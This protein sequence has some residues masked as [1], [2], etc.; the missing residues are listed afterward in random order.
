MPKERHAHD[1]ASAVITAIHDAAHCTEGVVRWHVVP[2]PAHNLLGFSEI[3]SLSIKPGWAEADLL[4][5]PSALGVLSGH[6]LNP[7]S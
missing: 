7:K 3:M 2:K 6:S 1:V 5:Q 4:L